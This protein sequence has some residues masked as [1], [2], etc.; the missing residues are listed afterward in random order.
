M[1]QQ[2]VADEDSLGVAG[3]LA[4]CRS[5]SARTYMRVSAAVVERAYTVSGGLLSA[6]MGGGIMFSCAA[7]VPGT[8]DLRKAV[9]HLSSPHRPSRS[10]AAGRDSK[11]S[12]GRRFR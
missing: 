9:A 10:A 1:P 6:G 3:P 7:G 2:R 11:S 8:F 12:R 5:A 4:F